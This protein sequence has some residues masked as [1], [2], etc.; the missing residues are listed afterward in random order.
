M[1]EINTL[2]LKPKKSVND[3]SGAETYNYTVYRWLL[4]QQWVPNQIYKQ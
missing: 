2:F 4:H 1:Q 3:P